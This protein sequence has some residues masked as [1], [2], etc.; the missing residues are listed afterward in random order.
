[1]SVDTEVLRDLSRAAFGQ[2]YR[3]E[4][5]LAVADSDDGLITQT[6]LA[7]ELGVS[8]SNV[9]APVRS[10]IGCGLLTQLPQ[11]DSRSKFLMR[12][13]SAAWEW[14]KELRLQAQTPTRTVLED[15]HAGQ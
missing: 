3:L 12:N 9:Q 5:M 4:V 8:V 10:L 6:E 11:G 2:A 15:H 13:R 7:R 1:M 14:V